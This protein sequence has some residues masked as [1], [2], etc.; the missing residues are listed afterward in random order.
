MQEN[1]KTSLLGLAES[2]SFD[3]ETISPKR[4]F[5]YF[6]KYGFQLHQGNFR[7]YLVKRRDMISWSYRTEIR[8]RTIMRSLVTSLQS[9]KRI[10]KMNIDLEMDGDGN[11]E[12]FGELSQ[13]LRKQK[14][15][16]NI[17][18]ITS[19]FANESDKRVKDLTEGLKRL[20]F[21]RNLE[22]QFK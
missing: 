12:K 21:I 5:Q 14:S 19:T 4:I 20:A 3:Y 9:T 8:K 7:K 11:D 1:P 13:A 2:Q 10:K 17:R 16:Q 22:I 15:L 18:I 6:A